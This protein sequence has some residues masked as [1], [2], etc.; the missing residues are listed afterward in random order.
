[1]CHFGLICLMWLHVH[2]L[3]DILFLFLAAKAQVMSEKS[4]QK[5][6]LILQKIEI[7]LCIKFI[8]CLLTVNYLLV[9]A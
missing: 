3:E 1:M 4:W 5:K 9:Y 7:T 6:R 8:L 2:N